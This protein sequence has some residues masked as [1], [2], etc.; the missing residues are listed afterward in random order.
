MLCWPF[1]EHFNRISFDFDNVLRRNNMSNHP[2]TLVIILFELILN[3]IWNRLVST[4]FLQ[5]PA[6]TSKIIKFAR[7]WHQIFFSGFWDLDPAPNVHP[8]AMAMVPDPQNLE[9][10]SFTSKNEKNN[11]GLHTDLKLRLFWPYGSACAGK[12]LQAA[13][14]PS[15]LLKAPPSCQAPK[16]EGLRL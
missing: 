5:T 16:A 12:P 7:K 10:S 4:F 14:S 1:F 3:T 15:Q 11:N 6:K 2:E 13:G 8:N 9:N